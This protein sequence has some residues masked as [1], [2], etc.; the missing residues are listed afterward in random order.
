VD[1]VDSSVDYV[2]YVTR[3]QW[4]AVQQATADTVTD[5]YN[6]LR[7][8][9][10]TFCRHLLAIKP[11][12]EWDDEELK[13]TF[14][15]WNAALRQRGLVLGEKEF[16]AA[17]KGIWARTKT[18]LGGNV[19]KQCYEEIEREGVL[20]GYDD[21]DE[22]FQKLISLCAKMGARSSN[23]IFFLACRTAGE[24]LGIHYKRAALWLRML[25]RDTIIVRADPP[26][27][28]KKKKD[29]AKEGRQE[30]YHY[31]FIGRS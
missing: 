26:K 20:P 30:T 11:R 4:S 9:F 15:E 27:A 21:Y 13:Q 16:F 18:P 12:E 28:K 10:H 2:D 8:S 17:I 19:A 24:L 3:D 22:G 25:C 23:G 14:L 5:D 1:Y 6:L 29:D 31:K 7:P